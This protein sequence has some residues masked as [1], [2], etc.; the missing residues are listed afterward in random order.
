VP[1]D[2]EFLPSLECRARF[3]VAVAAAAV[4]V[5]AMDVLAIRVEEDED[6]TDPAVEFRRGWTTPAF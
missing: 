1:S 2:E 4:T 5:F 3:L 6:A